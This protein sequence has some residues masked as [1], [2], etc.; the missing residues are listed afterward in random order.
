MSSPPP[1][2]PPHQT[3]F[4]PYVAPPGQYEEPKKGW[5]GCLI[6]CLVAFGL[7]LV[8]CAGAG[9]YI[10]ANAKTWVS[11]VARE[12]IKTVLADSG[13]P[14]EEQN[15]I[16]RQVNR[17]ADA[18]EAGDISN[19]ELAEI[20][21]ELAQSR[22]MGVITLQAVDA[23]YL[24][25]S[26]LSDEEKTEAK[27]TL[28]RVVRGAIE[29]KLSEQQMKDLGDHFLKPGSSENQKQLR[30][31]LT[32]EELRTFITEAKEMADGAEIPDEDYDV[33]LSEEIK[34]AIDKALQ[35]QE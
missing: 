27:R 32:D 35:S 3:G 22:L 17:V 23:K 7:C 5:S 18:Y 11:N 12:G 1:P 29:E 8:M 33:Q 31:S 34:K 9:L 10:R 6:G 2:P 4:D 20:M 24:Q 13:L 26:G 15:A 19:Q 16:Q 28:M 21:Q 14:Q 25:S 30:N